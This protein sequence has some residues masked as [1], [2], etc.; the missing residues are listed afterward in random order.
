MLAPVLI[1]RP[2]RKAFERNSNGFHLDTEIIIQL[3]I[4]RLPIV[5]LNIP[6]Y[7]GDEICHVKGIAYSLNV[8]V[9]TIHARLQELSLF[10]DSRR[11]VSPARRTYR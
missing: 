10:Y 4:A 11:H 8:V 5:E 6:T 3:V 9:A 7:Y 1:A 2:A